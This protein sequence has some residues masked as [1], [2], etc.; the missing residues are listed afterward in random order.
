MDLYKRF[1]FNPSPP[2]RISKTLSLVSLW[3]WKWKLPDFWDITSTLAHYSS[4]NLPVSSCDYHL[5]FQFSFSFGRLTFLQTQLWIEQ[6]ILLYLVF[7]GLLVWEY[8]GYLYHSNSITGSL[9]LM[10]CRHL[11]FN[12]LQTILVSFFT[13]LVLLQCFPCFTN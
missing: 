7:P 2:Y 3:I 5:G 1:S 9:F 8:S 6:F 10:S 11:K 13:N 4:Y 12:L